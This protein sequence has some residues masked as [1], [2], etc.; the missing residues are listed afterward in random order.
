M[1]SSRFKSATSRSIASGDSVPRSPRSL[2]RTKTIG[3]VASTRDA[4]MAPKP[5][6]SRGS[7]GGEGVSRAG[8]G[9]ARGPDDPRL[10]ERRDPAAEAVELSAVGVGAPEGGEQNPVALAGIRRQMGGVEGEGAGPRGRG[11]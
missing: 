9:G 1:A 7:R 5:A 3:F 11:G 8:W 10:A 4:S 6:T 2:A